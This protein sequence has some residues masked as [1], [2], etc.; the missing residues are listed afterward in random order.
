MLALVVVDHLKPKETWKA[1][2]TFKR[3]PGSAAGLI[4]GQTYRTLELLAGLV[5]ASGNDTALALADQLGIKGVNA[6]AAMNKKAKTMGLRQTVYGDV[7]GFGC[8]SCG[9][10]AREQ[11]FVLK[12][13]A[14]HPR[15]G[16]L[17][18]TRGEMRLPLF[19]ARRGHQ[20]RGR[21]AGLTMPENFLGGKTG[22]TIAA[23]NC[24][25]GIWRS[26]KGE[27]LA[28]ALG[29]GDLAAT[30]VKLD[31]FIQQKNL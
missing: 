3:P 25:A 4:P 15:L 18:R 8:P 5:A 27:I 20:L 1:P 24:L 21:L 28:I 11:W 13:V 29:G 2:V 22:Q 31:L 30:L 23:G 6:V 14:V 7:I 26:R 9:S 19:G 10:T 16:Q 17:L 12:A